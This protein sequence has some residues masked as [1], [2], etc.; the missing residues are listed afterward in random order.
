MKESLGISGFTMY[1]LMKKESQE[2][3]SLQNLQ[4]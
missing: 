2:V 1:D 3:T 4:N